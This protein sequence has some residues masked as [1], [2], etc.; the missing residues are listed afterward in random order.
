[1]VNIL[2][3][4]DRMGAIPSMEKETNSQARIAGFVG[5]DLRVEFSGGAPG[6]FDQTFLSR[7]AAR[8]IP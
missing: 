5:Q 2:V 6:L 3:P 1:V 7:H 4:L 8:I